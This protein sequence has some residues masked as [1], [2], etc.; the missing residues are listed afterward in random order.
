LRIQPHEVIRNFTRNGNHFEP[1][2]APHVTGILTH[3]PTGSVRDQA[4]QDYGAKTIEKLHEEIG[5]TGLGLLT[6]NE[7]DL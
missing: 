6:H 5:P 7:F 4:E 1:Q 2:A 3:L